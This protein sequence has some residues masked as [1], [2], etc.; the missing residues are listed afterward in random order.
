[1][2]SLVRSLEENKTT[3]HITAVPSIFH[4]QKDQEVRFM[5]PVT[6]PNGIPIIRPNPTIKEGAIAISGFLA[7]EYRTINISSPKNNRGLTRKLVIIS[8]AGIIISPVAGFIVVKFIESSTISVDTTEM[9]NPGR[10]IAILLPIQISLGVS[11][12]AQSEAI[13]P[14]TFSFI[15][16]RL[17]KAQIKVIRINNGR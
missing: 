8:G 12:V 14:F 4:K 2:F 7:R 6:I 5:F 15:I 1:M 9:T 16:G 17:E 10:K 3:A 11:V 13:L